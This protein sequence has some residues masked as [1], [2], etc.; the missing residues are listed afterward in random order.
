MTKKLLLVAGAAAVLAFGSVAFAQFEP[1]PHL[2]AAHDKIEAAVAEL[3][4][5]NDGTKQ[6]GGHRDRAEQLLLEAQ[7][8]IK[9]AAIFANAHH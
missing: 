1:H 2:L 9:E 4:A 6:F 3:R 7:G 8:E 5:A